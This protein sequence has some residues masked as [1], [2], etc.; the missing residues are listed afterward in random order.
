MSPPY[1]SG[2]LDDPRELGPL[3]VLGKRVAFLGRGKAALRRET[4]LIERSKLAR[5]LD[6]ALDYGLVLELAELGRD[7]AKH[8]DLAAFGQQ[9]Q[10]LQAAGALGVPFE[11]ISVYREIVEQLVR[12]LLVAAGADEGRTEVAAAEMRGD[13]HVGRL[14]LERRIEDLAIA[15]ELPVRVVAAVA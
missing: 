14:G 12:N 7:E 15:I 8:D 13:H 6:A 10:R 11:E 5:F 4:E 1:V 9:A 3:L 2:D